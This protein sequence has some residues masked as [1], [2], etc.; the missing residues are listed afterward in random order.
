MPIPRISSLRSSERLLQTEGRAGRGLG[1][2]V[3]FFALLDERVL[4]CWRLTGL[5][6]LGVGAARLAL[7][8]GFAG[9][10]FD[11]L[12]DILVSLARGL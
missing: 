7:F 12:E 5:A 3:G 8:A 11:L 1:A 2:G 4:L 9:F 6:L 10:F